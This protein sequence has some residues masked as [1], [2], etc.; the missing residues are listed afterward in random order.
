[1]IVRKIVIAILVTASVQV[2]FRVVGAEAPASLAVAEGHLFF[3]TKRNTLF[4]LVDIWPNRETVE[5]ISPADRQN[6]LISGATTIARNL[7]DK[8]EMSAIDSVRVE[9]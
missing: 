6:W 5:A 1:M 2:P 9:F 8:P 3:A 4:A 7:L